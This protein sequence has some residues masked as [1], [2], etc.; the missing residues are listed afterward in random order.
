L[1]GKDWPV[2]A[3]PAELEQQVQALPAL[4]QQL[5]QVDRSVLLAVL[6]AREAVRQAGWGGPE[7]GEVG[8]NIGSSRGATA[9][10][11]KHFA[12][13]HDSPDGSVSALSSPTTTLGN[14][15]SWVAQDLQ[16][17]G[18]V[19]SHSIT[20][21]T[22][23][24]ALAN[25]M[26]W[27]RAGMA[28][29]FLAGGAEAPLTP[30]TL[31]QMEALGI[32]SPDLNHSFPCRP[33]HP[34]QRNTFVLGEGAAV[35]ALEALSAEEAGGGSGTGRIAIE[36]IGFGVE[37]IRSKTG[38]SAEGLH[39]QKAMT[40]ALAQAPNRLPPDLI[41]LHA[42][43]T[44]AGDAAELKAVQEVFGTDSPALFSNKWQF[45]HSLGASAAL[46]LAQ[47]V[48]ILQQQWVPEFPYPTVFRPKPLRELNRIMVNA[49]GFGGNATSLIVSRLPS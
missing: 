23:L 22:A 49:A 41:L 47:A 21:S 38:I 40:Q 7:A 46:S 2:G 27:L 15:S 44:V 42:P 19:I 12:S 8:V 45:G 10:F 39:F 43:G 5:K 16:M 24:Q 34:A 18:P 14:I 3:L 28:A 1:A 30:F 36:A 31:A 17:E 6:A 26:A 32:Y 33:C 25:G 37:A 4:N 11:E 13:F 48:E 29:R 9:S 20:C 35:F